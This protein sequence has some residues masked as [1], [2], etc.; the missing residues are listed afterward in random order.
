MPATKKKIKRPTGLHPLIAFQD[1]KR[2]VSLRDWDGWM[3]WV[4][5][6]KAGRNWIVEIDPFEGGDHPKYL[7]PI[8]AAAANH[9]A[10][11]GER[12]FNSVFSLYGG[13]GYIAVNTSKNIMPFQAQPTSYMQFKAPSLAIACTVASRLLFLPEECFTDTNDKYLPSDFIH[14]IL[15]DVQE[16]SRTDIK[17]FVFEL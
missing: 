9:I 1:E 16:R 12:I 2:P 17:P 5:I 15:A 3:P 11:L 14:R 7:T 10:T 6:C 4:A 13:D 8:G